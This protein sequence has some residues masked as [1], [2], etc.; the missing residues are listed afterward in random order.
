M[1]PVSAGW[2]L[3]GVPVSEGFM[4]ACGTL[5]IVRCEFFQL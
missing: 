5:L 4:G 2:L 3:L 1:L